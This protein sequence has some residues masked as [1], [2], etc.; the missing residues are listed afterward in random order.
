[1][2]LLALAFAGIVLSAPA[3]LEK[4]GCGDIHVAGIKIF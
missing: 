2:H 1:M 4:P 3:A